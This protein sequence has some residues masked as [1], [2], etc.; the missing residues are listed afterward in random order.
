LTTDDFI[1]D[2]GMNK[3]HRLLLSD[4]MEAS[5]GS[6]SPYGNPDYILDPCVEEV[7]EHS[8]IFD[9]VYSGGTKFGNMRLPMDASL[10]P[11]HNNIVYRSEYDVVIFISIQNSNFWTCR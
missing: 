5:S 4:N 10:S 8:T 2:D 7:E 9:D 11:A 3:D 1:A 6:D